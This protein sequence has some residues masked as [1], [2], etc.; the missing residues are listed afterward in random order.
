MKQILAISLTVSTLISCKQGWTD[1]NKQE[2]LGGCISGAQKNM[3]AAKAKPYC[4]CMLQK[5]QLRYQSPVALQYLKNDTA[6]YN[7]GK[8]C[9]Q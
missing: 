8:A 3:D 4:I 7:M 5:L 1:K 6:V 9:L 2:F